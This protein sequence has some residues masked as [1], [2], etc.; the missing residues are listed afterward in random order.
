MANLNGQNIGTNYKGFLNLDS[1]INTP[2]D[3]T[4]RAVTDGMG[5]SSPLQLSA[6]TYTSASN[7]TSLLKIIGTAT[8]GTNADTLYGA[9]LTPTLSSNSK[10]GLFGS[11]L[12]IAGVTSGTGYNTYGN[13]PMVDIDS[14]SWTGTEG[15]IGNTCSLRIKGS[16]PTMIFQGSGV[17]STAFAFSYDG[18]SRMFCQV[19]VSGSPFIIGANGISIN[20]GS[21]PTAW[22]DLNASTTA[23][24][25]IR[26]RT[27]VAPTTPNDGDMWQDGTNFK[28]Q[29]N[30]VTK[31]VTLL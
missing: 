23:R 4:L 19:G 25:T 20:G 28:I 27:G 26:M 21:A 18:T 30:G 22:C 10:T 14:T 6:A 9:L 7:N 3:E 13:S 11:A 31:T 2:L 15:V 12:K 8:A 16:N 1:T 29:I 5:T 24:A 17:A